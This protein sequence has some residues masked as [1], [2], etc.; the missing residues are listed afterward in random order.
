MEVTW[1][2]FKRLKPFSSRPEV[3]VANDVKEQKFLDL[4]CDCWNEL[5][6]CRPDAQNVVYRLGTL[7][8]NI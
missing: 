6:D 1:Y 8:Q 5:P 3:P 2:K 4:M 7:L